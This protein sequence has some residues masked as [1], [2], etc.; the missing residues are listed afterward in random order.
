[1]FPLRWDMI[2]YV[3]MGSLSTQEKMAHPIVSLF[4]PFKASI[5]TRGGARNL[6]HHLDVCCP[7]GALR[8]DP[9]DGSG[10]DSHNL[11]PKNPG[12]KKC[13]CPCSYLQSFCET[14]A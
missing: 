10:L 2:I 13:E 11:G 5:C 12:G 6:H 14:A 1:M 7:L 8:Q 3:F 4:P 9:K